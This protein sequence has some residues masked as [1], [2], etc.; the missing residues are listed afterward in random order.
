MLAGPI[1]LSTFCTSEPVAVP[2]TLMRL[3]WRFAMKVVAKAVMARTMKGAFTT[4]SK[5]S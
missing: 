5:M 4:S 1:A 2:I 3:D